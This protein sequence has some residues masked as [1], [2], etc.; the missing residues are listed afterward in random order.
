MCVRWQGGAGARQ[1]GE[2]RSSSSS[3]GADHQPAAV[4]RPSERQRGGQDEADAD[5][6]EHGEK[7]CP[8]QVQRCIALS[9]QPISH[10][11]FKLGLD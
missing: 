11:L 4:H 6:Q 1:R 3:A 9:L 5:Q 10:L 2:G 8:N 7:S